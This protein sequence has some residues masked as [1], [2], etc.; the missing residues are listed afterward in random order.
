MIGRARAR[1][2]QIWLM[3][4][5]SSLGRRAVTAAKTVQAGRRAGGQEERTTRAASLRGQ[6]AHVGMPLESAR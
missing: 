3:I 4:R 2:F 6:E 1:G 5:L